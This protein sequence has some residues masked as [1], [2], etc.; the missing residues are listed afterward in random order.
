MDDDIEIFEEF[1]S[2]EVDTSTEGESERE[3]DGYRFKL[4]I[5]S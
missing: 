2:V 4:E 3:S 1:Y 5:D